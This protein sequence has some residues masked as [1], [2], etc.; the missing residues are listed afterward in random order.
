MLNVL[1]FVAIDLDDLPCYDEKSQYTY[2]MEVEFSRPVAFTFLPMGKDEANKFLKK[3]MEHLGS[4]E[5]K[6]RT[7]PIFIN[8]VTYIW[9]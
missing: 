5:L 4:E 3:K 2:E 8:I 1:W 9:I 6:E 7:K